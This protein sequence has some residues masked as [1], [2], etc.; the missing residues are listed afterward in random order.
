M[1]YRYLPIRGLSFAFRVLKVADFIP[2]PML[3]YIPIIPLYNTLP[4]KITTE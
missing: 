4:T 1:I 2:L 3:L